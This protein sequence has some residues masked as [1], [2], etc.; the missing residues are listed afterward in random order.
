MTRC[1]RAAFWEFVGVLM[2]LVQGGMVGRL[3]RRF[4]EAR[5]LVG[6]SVLCVIGLWGIAPAG[7][8]AALGAAMVPLALGSGLGQPAER[9][10]LPHGRGGRQGD[11]WGSTSPSDRWPGFWTAVGTVFLRAPGTGLP[12]LLSGFV[13]AGAVWLAARAVRALPEPAGAREHGSQT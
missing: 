3:S 10:H 1:R 11:S 9:A 5:L 8:Y 6:G 12:Y 7:S 4:G 2:V 13:M